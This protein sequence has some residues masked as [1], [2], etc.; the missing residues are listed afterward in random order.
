M[1]ERH[2]TWNDDELPLILHRLRDGGGGEAW[3]GMDEHGDGPGVQ[4]PKA[5]QDLL[6]KIGYA[7][8]PRII[9][10]TSVREDDGR[11]F[12]RCVVREFRI[13]DMPC[14]VP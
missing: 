13:T 12:V 9:P 11:S 14:F 2:S 1:I 3:F 5:L 7:Q 8:R 4:D 6:F 10:E